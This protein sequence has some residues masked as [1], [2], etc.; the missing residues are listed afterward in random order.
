MIG[1]CYVRVW[2][3]LLQHR[4]HKMVKM[5]DIQVYI[6]VVITG[7]DNLQ[8]LLVLGVGCFFFFFALFLYKRV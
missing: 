6:V 4:F 2:E 3:V 5:S 1:S 8:R 7:I